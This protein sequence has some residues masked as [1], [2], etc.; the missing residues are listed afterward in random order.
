[1][2][3]EIKWAPQQVMAM[4]A[5]EQ[6]L[7]GRIHLTDKRQ[8]FYLAG[9]AGSGKTTL[10]RE[11]ANSGAG[12]LVEFAAFTGKAAHVL[13]KAGCENARTI[14]SLIYQPSPKSKQ[15]LLDME[16]ELGAL[17]PNDPGRHQ[18][19]QAIEDEKVKL[20]RPAFRLNPDSE[21]KD[22]DLVVIDEV[23][24]VD[25]QMGSDLCSFGKPI[26]VLGDPAQLPPVAQSQGYFTRRDPDFML[27]E[28]H[29]QA[30]GSPVLRLAT[31]VRSGGDLQ[32][33]DY[34][35]SR[36]LPP[37]GLTAEQAMTFDQIICGKNETRKG[38]NARIR[39]LLGR[40]GQLPEVGDRLICLRNDRETGLLNGSFWS[41]LDCVVVD[42]DKVNL[43]IEDADEGGSPLV[44]TAHRHHFEGRELP[45]WSA[46]EA[47]EFDYGY[48]ITCHKAQGSQWGNVL[49]YDQSWIAREHRRKWLY[50]AL[51]RASESVTVVLS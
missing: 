35:S 42:E 12:G 9:Y 32:V 49:V 7:E 6:W 13:R 31:L 43:I 47:H 24:M 45:Y 22:A 29:R 51:T 33:G 3:T 8:C 23:S 14:H 25:Q 48:A 38:I 11:F 1:M 36:V 30:E 21:I 40:K 16:E 27:T 4:E 41:V 20:K 44:V 34:G 37:K 39:K 10:A 2:K 15:A 50:T 28:V 18:L 17:E 19:I 26:L 46:R 5:V